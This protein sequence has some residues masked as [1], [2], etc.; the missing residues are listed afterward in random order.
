MADP[1]DLLR[2]FS[3]FPQNRQLLRDRF[4]VELVEGSRKL[5]HVFLFTDLLLCTKLKKQ[6]AGCVALQYTHLS[7]EPSV[8]RGTQS[9]ICQQTDLR[10]TSDRV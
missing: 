5:R 3:F 4:M 2:T 10:R 8:H 9:Y 6:P 7:P 1:V